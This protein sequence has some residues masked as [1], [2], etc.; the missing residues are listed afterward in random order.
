MVFALMAWDKPGALPIRLDNRPDH[1]AYLDS[2]GVVQKAGQFLDPETGRPFLD[3]DGQPCGSLI[4]LD[5][6]DMAAAQ[7]WADDD[8]YAKAGL[9]ADVKITAWKQV[10]G[11]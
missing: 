8:P 7:A 1:L 9:F 6:P 11:S 5:V 4:V 10:V 3:P 2:T